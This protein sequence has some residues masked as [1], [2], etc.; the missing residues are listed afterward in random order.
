[1][2]GLSFVK[3]KKPYLIGR[4]VL[5]ERENFHNNDDDNKLL[6]YLHEAIN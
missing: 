5:W 4:K 2:N 6:P 1:M 3:M